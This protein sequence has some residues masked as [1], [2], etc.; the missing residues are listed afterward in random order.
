MDDRRL[1]QMAAAARLD[2]FLAR[3]VEEFGHNARDAAETNRRIDDHIA[4]RS[5]G[6]APDAGS[7]R[8]APAP[9][10]DRAAA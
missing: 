6:I 7:P 2:A 3:A 10:F 4:A 1:A 8:L 5:R 9:G